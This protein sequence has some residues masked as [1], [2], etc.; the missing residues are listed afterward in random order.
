MRKLN[1]NELRQIQLEIL[2]EVHSFCVSRHLSYSLCGGTLLGAVRHGGYIPWDDDIDIFM[3]RPDYERF[4]LEYR[5]D[6]NELLNLKK[7][8]ACL[9]LVLKVCRKG[10]A[11]IDLELKRNLWG[12]NIDIFP[13]DGIPVNADEHIN[14]ILVLRETLSHICPHY[15]VIPEHKI[16]WFVK[17]I[18][19]RIRYPYFGSSLSLKKQ[20]DSLAAATPFGETEIVGAILGCYGKREMLPKDIFQKY[21]LISFEG[22]NYYCINQPEEYLS[23]LYGDYMTLPPIEKRITHHL[24]DAFIES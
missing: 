16:L 18:L 5:S 24:Y 11:M 21:R 15:K 9:E 10:T 13:V 20:I 4:A 3:P 1:I 19:K 6:R 2:D 22:R 8:S 14:K 12:V 23:A 7:H 17:Y